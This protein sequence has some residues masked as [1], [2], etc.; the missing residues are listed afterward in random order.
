MGKSLREALAEK[1]VQLRARGIA[2][3]FVPE[4]EE[5]ELI[6]YPVNGYDEGDRPRKLGKRAQARRQGPAP[7]IA[8]PQSA[9][10]GRQPARTAAGGSAARHAPTRADGALGRPAPRPPSVSRMLQ[11]RA[12]QRRQETNQRDELRQQLCAVRGADVDEEG[13]KTFLDALEQ[14]TGALPPPQVVLEAMREASSDN[15]EAVGNAVRR[16]YRRARPAS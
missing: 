1:M 12:E 6:S 3:E 7:R 5:P 15:P 9:G 10:P 11:H 4:L 8:R 14:E 13:L 16:Y 2:P